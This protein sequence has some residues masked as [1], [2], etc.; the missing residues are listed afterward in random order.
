MRLVARICE[1]DPEC[2]VVLFVARG[3]AVAEAQAVLQRRLVEFLRWSQ[4]LLLASSRLVEPLR[5]RAP[6]AR[7]H[8]KLSSA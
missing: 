1:V 3:L 6:S 2:P 5:V 4:E 8:E 7:V